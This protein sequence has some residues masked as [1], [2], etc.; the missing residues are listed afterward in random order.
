MESKETNTEE[1]PPSS[2]NPMQLDPI[3]T[4]FLDKLISTPCFPALQHAANSPTWE[5]YM[6]DKVTPIKATENFIPITTSDKHMLYA[7]WK[8]AVSIKI[9]G[10]SHQILKNKLT[11]LWKTTED[12]SLIDL[13]A[14]FSLIKFTNKDNLDHVLHNGPWFVYNH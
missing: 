4:T 14:D 12:L 8:L 1:T 11:T 13:G 5:D 6:I 9:V 2:I 3:H 7:P 10:I